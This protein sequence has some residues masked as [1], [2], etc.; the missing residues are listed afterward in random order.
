M[1]MSTEQSI[2]KHTLPSGLNLLLIPSSRSPVVAL[3]GWV[4]YGAADETD[5]IAGVAHLFEH[6]LFKGT[7][8]RAVGEIAKEIEGLGG[9]LNAY[10]TYDHTVMH[11]TLASKHANKGLEIL[12][13]SLLNSV[14]EESELENERPV[15][16]EEIK[17]RNDMPGAKAGDL[18]RTEL[19]SGHP[20]SRP[21]IGFDHVVSGIT[22][23]RIVKEYKS[24]YTNQ[25]LFIVVSGEFNEADIIAQCEKLFANTPNGPGR[26]ERPEAKKINSQK[27]V[28]EKHNIP[29]PILHLG[30]RV[31]GNVGAEVAA[32]D[33]LA[34]II[35][36]GESSRFH[37][38]L[39]QDEKLVRGLGASCWSPKDDGSFSIGIKADPHVAKNFSKIET[40]L[41]ETLYADVSEKELAKAKKNLLSDAVYSKESVDGLAERYAYCESIA[42]DWNADTHYLNSIRA[43]TVTDLHR[44]REK[45]LNWNHLLCTGAIPEKLAMPKFSGKTPTLSRVVKGRVSNS[46]ATAHGFKKESHGVYSRNFNGL[47]V[48]LRPSHDIPLFSLRWVGLGGQRLEPANKAGLGSLWARTVCDG[49]RLPSGRPLGREQINDIIDSAGASLASF[50]GRNSYGF[51]LDG[52]TEDFESLFEVLLASKENP[53]FDAKV[54]AQ[55]KTHQA[56]DIRS[57]KQNPGACLNDDFS[58]AMFPKH[59]YGRN[60]LG[61]LKTLKALTPKD[62]ANY[63]KKLCAQPQVLC[64]TGDISPERA[65]DLLEEHLGNKKFPTKTALSKVQPAKHKVQTQFTFQKLDKE[66]SH[67]FWG[68]PTCNMKHK[69]RWPLMALSSVL[70]GQGGRLF[71]E[72][73]DKLSLCYS[74]APTHLEGVDDGY[75]AFYMGTSPDKIPVALEGMEKELNKIIDAGISTKEWKKACNFVTGNHEIGQQSLG[76][77]SMGM[78]LDELYGLGFEEYF[79]FSQHLS[80]ITAE[81]IRK[82]VKKY[83]DPKR[84]KSQVFSV[85]GPSKPSGPIVQALIS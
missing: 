30:W 73:R 14:V 18:F 82:V 79:Q 50:H 45:Y 83:L 5:D 67:L 42:G 80:K 23:E 24:H 7:T 3:Q 31:P 13:D 29:D 6:L 20:Y 64:I 34:L 55:A 40:A 46:P 76:S 75:F 22:R 77:Q 69:D 49:A 60:S 51:Q 10:T 59:A 28:F 38:R 33:A 44:A 27:S 19:F 48:L 71:I 65:K 68:F 12:S 66:Q 16:L 21:V 1:N 39:V 58:S 70:S 78:A 57:Q 81:D 61:D 41:Y 72:L 47:K 25:N 56:Q 32:L 4:T 43:L 85:V 26:R 8:N 36:Q 15:I 53:T 17:R 2:K 9:D 37:R 62:A 84:A 11:M 74:V 54:F 63:H 52:L 35:G